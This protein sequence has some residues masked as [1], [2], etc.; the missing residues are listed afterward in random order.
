V[1]D[2]DT[3]L[4][5]VADLADPHDLAPVSAIRRHGDR[6]R[7][8]QLLTVA[9]AVVV[10]LAAASLLVPDGQP[11]SAPPAHER[12]RSSLSGW[13]VAGMVHVPHDGQMLDADGSLW[14]IDRDDARAKDGVPLG[15]MYRIDPATR[16][17]I[18]QIPGAVGAWPTVADGVAWLNTQAVT[19]AV[20]TR[21]DLAAG[22][23]TRVRTGATKNTAPAAVAVTG[24]RVWVGDFGEGTVTALD[25][26][27]GQVVGSHQVAEPYSA[28]RGWTATDGTSVWIPVYDSGSVVR[29]DAATGRTM[30]AVELPVRTGP[31][32]LLL[33]GD[34]LYAGAENTVYAVDVSTLGQERI[35][36][37]ATLP[38][39]P[40]GSQPLRLI[41][42]F[43][44][45]WTV[46]VEP[47]ELLRMDPETLR[48][49]GR[50]PIPGRV[51]DDDFPRDVVA[52]GGSIWVRSPDRVYQL[53][54]DR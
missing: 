38:A 39:G 24:G 50:L 47:S 8:R 42:A 9:A 44:S 33:V 11:E 51:P 54:Q 29:I 48:V 34:V 16:E 31:E 12:V 25:V 46:R 5:Q 1:N 14:V 41:S 20:V 19:P 37:T 32:A 52:S 23:V 53:K 45:I 2:L 17:V 49:T 27:T 3:L 26:A 7:R 28:V 35:L 10:A 13:H 6:L 36:A 4:E 43:G 15:A 30:S 22:R 21:V 40:T 18:D